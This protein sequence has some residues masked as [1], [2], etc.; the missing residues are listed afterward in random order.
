MMNKKK[1]IIFIIIFMIIISLF[2]CTVFIRGQR[3]I[4]IIE[5]KNLTRIPTPSVENYVDE[6]FQEDLETSI[7]DQ[8][9]FGEEIKFKF[10]SLQASFIHQLQKDIMTLFSQKNTTSKIYDSQSYIPISQ[11]IYTYKDDNYMIF[12]PRKLNKKLKEDIDSF[13]SVYNKKLKDIESY[14]YLIN[15]SKSIDF[16]NINNDIYEY[17]EKKLQLIDSDCLKIKSY[18]QYKDYFYQTDHHWN[19]KGSYQGYQDIIHMMCPND[20]LLKPIQTKTFDTYFY[21]S[22]A[23]KT[24]LY[25]NKE[26]FTIYQ[27]DVKAH[28]TYIDGLKAPY[29]NEEEYFLGNYSI[30]DGYNHYRDYYGGDFAEVMYDFHQEDQE[31]LLVIAP[32]YSNSINKLVASHFNKTYFIDLRYN[33]SF[34]IDSY[35]KDKD[36]D[37]VLVMLSI[38]HM[39]SGDFMLEEKDGF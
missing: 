1:E 28:D 22:H 6:S 19:Y 17:I 26:K 37:K 7:I 34:D 30:V 38:D 11:D 15:Q 9:L 20:Q 29:G 27:Y 3:D 12:K 13:T 10:S 18:E 23:R 21:G 36:I 16:D 5:N 24:S 33:Q 32:S 39:T 8:F 14:F 25:T 35:L 2:I 31:N 4:S